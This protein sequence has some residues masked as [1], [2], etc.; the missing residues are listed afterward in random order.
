MS[1][2]IAFLLGLRDGFRSGGMLSSGITY[3]DSPESPRSR[4]Y[5][6]GATLGE[7]VRDPLNRADRW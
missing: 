2:L 7:R 4:A 3:N 5:D 6:R 1:R